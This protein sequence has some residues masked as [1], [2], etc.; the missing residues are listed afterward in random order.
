MTTP[1]M[2]PDEMV[3]ALAS[4]Y[5]DPD[6]PINGGDLVEY[7]GELLTRAGRFPCTDGTDAA[8][9][10]DPDDPTPD[11]DWRFCPLPK[12]HA[13]PHTHTATGGLG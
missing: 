6:A 9:Y 2:T 7:V 5:V 1:T 10:G 8:D 11:P 12:G 4:L 3:S 13:G